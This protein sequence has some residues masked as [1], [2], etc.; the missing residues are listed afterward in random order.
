MFYGTL[1]KGF[2]RNDLLKSQRFIK[3]VRTEPFYRLY[4][5]GGFP[6]MVKSPNGISVKGELWEVDE[7]CVKTLDMIEGHPTFFKRSRIKLEE[8]TA[9]A[10]IFQLPVDGYPECGDCWDG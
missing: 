3:E 2:Q 8:G 7:E 9:E 10:Y 5:H 6:T 4:D 1:K